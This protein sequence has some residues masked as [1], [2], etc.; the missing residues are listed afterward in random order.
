VA[1]CHA[2]ASV[3]LPLTV[4]QAWAAV[5]DWDS[6]SRWMLLTTVRGT[7]QRG[8]GVGGGVSART[9]VGPVGFTDDMVITEWDPPSVCRVRHLG[10]L[11]RGEGGFV[12]SEA[13]GGSRFTW[14]EDVVPPLGRLGALAGLLVW[15]LVRPGVE[16]VM[17]VSLR[18]L[19]RE[20]SR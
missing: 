6:Q 5:V 2:E 7:E 18:R 17:R 12:V 15:P 1:I 4:D 8:V 20:V 11:V 19:A 13:P 9:A 3:E 16:L 10:R 14:S